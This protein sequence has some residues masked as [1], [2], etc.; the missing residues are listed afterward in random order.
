MLLCQRIPLPLK[1]LP[2]LR[3]GLSRPPSSSI[4]KVFILPSRHGLHLG[5]LRHAAICAFNLGHNPTAL[6]D[7]VLFIEIKL[8]SNH[9]DFHL[10]RKYEPTGGFTLTMKET[11]EM[12]GKFHF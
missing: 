12:L 3:N 2:T 10:K 1:V 5:A 7:G 11:R 4:S 6:E 9:K 8:K